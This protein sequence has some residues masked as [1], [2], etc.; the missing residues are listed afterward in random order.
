M[1]TP[2][3]KIGSNDH[4]KLLEGNTPMQLRVEFLKDADAHSDFYT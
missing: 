2:S 3:H 4:S 1:S